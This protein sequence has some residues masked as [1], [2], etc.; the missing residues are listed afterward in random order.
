MYFY[1]LLHPKNVQVVPVFL[2]LQ[3][4]MMVMIITNREAEK[5]TEKERRRGGQVKGET[6][7]TI[8]LMHSRAD[9][10]RETLTVKATRKRTKRETREEQD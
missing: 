2:P 1:A 8:G 7:S 5:K 6:E 3:P 9:S 4:A 10:R